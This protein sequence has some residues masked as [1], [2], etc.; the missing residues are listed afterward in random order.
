MDEVSLRS[1]AAQ[2]HGVIGRRE[3]VGF[4]ASPSQIRNRLATGE[5]IRL[6]PAVFAIA[7]A[8]V[9]WMQ[10]ARAQALSLDGLVSHRA[11]AYLHGIDGFRAGILD[12][13]V[14]QTRG[15]QRPQIRLRRSTQMHLA[16]PQVVH[17]VPVTGVAR[18][19]LDVAADVGPRRLETLVDAVLRQQMVS[20]ADLYEV[21][22]RHS[23]QGR[24]G[25][26]RLRQLLDHRYG[27]AVIPDSRWNRMVGQLLADSS[28][29]EPQYEYVVCTVAGEFVARVDLA[30]PRQRLAIELDSVRFHLNRESFEQDARRRNRLLNE[31]WRVLTF[32]WSD[33]SN[34]PAGL[35]RSVRAARGQSF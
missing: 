29:P 4:G 3:A 34:D 8:P 21:L 33:Y 7:G 11:A 14:A 12:V 20:W 15:R 23:V 19:V 30:Y 2:N 1:Y 24:N 13:T 27:D 10:S 32:T 28:L 25:C 31:G 16:D 6:A 26:G 22:V 17:S 5:W 35:I 9:T 18:T